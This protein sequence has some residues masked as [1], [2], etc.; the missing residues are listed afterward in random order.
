MCL[1]SD[2]LI[3]DVGND[4]TA[5]ENGEGEEVVEKTIMYV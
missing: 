5:G 4:G 1:F 2:L 3:R